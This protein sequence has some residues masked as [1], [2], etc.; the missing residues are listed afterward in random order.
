MMWASQLGASA[1]VHATPFMSNVVSAAGEEAVPP[2]G[3]TGALV[4]YTS[5][6]VLG[7]TVVGFLTG[8][9]V[10]GWLYK[11]SEEENERLRKLIDDKVY[12]LIEANT[13]IN[14]KATEVMKDIN[15]RQRT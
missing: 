6:G 12:P 14:E 8:K 3:L 2:D 7:L 15:T 11:K 10:P 4:Q 5:Y 1:L 13:R 9:L